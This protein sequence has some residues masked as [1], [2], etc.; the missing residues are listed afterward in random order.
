MKTLIFH[1]AMMRSRKAF[2][3]KYGMPFW[4]D[5]KRRS[6]VIFH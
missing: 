6:G 5:F 4:L 3:A 1:L 2:T